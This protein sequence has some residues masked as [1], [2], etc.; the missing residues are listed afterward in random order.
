MSIPWN[1]DI[2]HLFIG[3]SHTYEHTTAE[4]RRFEPYTQSGGIV[5]LHDAVSCSG[6]GLATSEFLRG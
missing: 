6:V 3:T 2:E 5:T 4:L 1:E